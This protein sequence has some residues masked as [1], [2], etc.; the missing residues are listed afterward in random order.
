M[1]TLVIDTEDEDRGRDKFLEGL[2]KAIKG[3]EF[4]SAG[5]EGILS[6][7]HLEDTCLGQSYT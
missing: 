4:Y 7:F 2:I 5:K 1:C 6:V 3:F